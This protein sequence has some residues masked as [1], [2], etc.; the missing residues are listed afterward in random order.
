MTADFL[1]FFSFLERGRRP[2]THRVGVKRSAAIFLVRTLVGVSVATKVDWGG[3]WVW[4]VDVT[5]VQWRVIVHEVLHFNVGSVWCCRWLH[6]PSPCKVCAPRRSPTCLVP[7]A[8]VSRLGSTCVF[9]LDSKTGT[10]AQNILTILRWPFWRKHAPF[11]LEHRRSSF[12][13]L[14]VLSMTFNDSHGYV[15]RSARGASGGP[16]RLLVRLQRASVCHAATPA[17]VAVHCVSFAK[18]AAP[19]PVVEYLTLACVRHTGAFGVLRACFCSPVAER[20][21]SRRLAQ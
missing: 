5:D 3:W 6:R 2:H 7:Y 21:S 9:R 20:S 18:W 17:P 14:W 1:N 15:L 8:V 16:S 10:L 11:K 12:V 19:A 4:T 13:L